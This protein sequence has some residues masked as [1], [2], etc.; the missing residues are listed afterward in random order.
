M[1]WPV[2]EKKLDPLFYRK[3]AVE[4]AISRIS[5]SNMAD[6]RRMYSHALGTDLDKF[7]LLAN[8]KFN[9]Q[10]RCELF[11]IGGKHLGIKNPFMNKLLRSACVRS[12]SNRESLRDKS[13]KRT[14]R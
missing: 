13:A 5:S 11:E 6:M 4:T 9:T 12:G 7:H 8:E 14:E 10:A 1:R 3:Q 2:A